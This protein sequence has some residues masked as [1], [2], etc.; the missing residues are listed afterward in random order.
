MKLGA[1]QHR[2]KTIKEVERLPI[3]SQA[4]DPIPNPARISSGHRKT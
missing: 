4:K 1:G 2:F 3:D